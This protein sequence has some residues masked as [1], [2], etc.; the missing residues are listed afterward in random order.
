MGE[1]AGLFEDLELGVGELLEPEVGRLD[2]WGSGV[3]T[4][5]EPEG[6][7]QPAENV[8]YPV[9][10]IAGEIGSER[11][12]RAGLMARAVVMLDTGGIDLLGGAD[13]IPSQGRYGWCRD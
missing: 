3:A 5:G 11:G 6:M 4:P 13:D 7:I 10:K 12:V 8:V 1:V 9:I 2:L